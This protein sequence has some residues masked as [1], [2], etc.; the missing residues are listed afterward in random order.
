VVETTERQAITVV[1]IAGELDATS[2][3]V[4][5]P[6]LAAAIARGR[7]VVV[8]LGDCT[9]VDVSGL[10]MLRAAHDLARESSVPFVV[11]LPFSGRSSVRRLVLELA[12][13]LVPFRFVPRLERAEALVAAAV[14]PPLPD[15]TRLQGL[16][17]KIWEAAERREELLA[18]LDTLL[19]E[20]R[21]ALEKRQRST[22]GSER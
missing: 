4:F 14:E 17:A 13:D 11:V 19:F 12:P 7:P 21:Q 22:G 18:R 20:Q 8:D 15:S 6:R 2:C 5:E 3:D 10:R 16:R 9:F 1:G